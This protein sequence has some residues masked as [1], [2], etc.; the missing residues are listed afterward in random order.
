MTAAHSPLAFLYSG[1]GAQWPG[2]GQRLLTESPAFAGWMQELDAYIRPWAHFSVL[3]E[4]CAP[5]ES[6]RL[7]EASVAQPLL[8][9]MQVALTRLLRAEGL[10]AAAVAGHSVGEIAAAWAAGRLTLDEGIR[11]V[12]ARSKVQLRARGRGTMAAV[13]LPEAAM[14][15]ILV[16]ADN[17]VVIAGVNSPRS[18]TL[19]GTEAALHALQPQVRARR[20]FF[21]L[22]DLE[23]AFHSPQMDVLHAA[24]LQRLS[25]LNPTVQGN[26]AFVSTVTGARLDD[27]PLDADYW[28]R[29]VREP[30]RF[31]DALAA[32]L[33]MGCRT[34]VEIG[35]HAILQRYV[36]ECCSVKEIAAT[37]V[38]IQK[39]A[40]DGLR[41]LRTAIE[42]VRTG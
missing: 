11:V 18:V 32:L 5:P 25:G 39:K 2:M 27:A 30:V 26:C 34:F 35:P 1:N 4:M 7:G 31:A 13:G 42:A 23:Y 37:T 14:R 41:A 24:L 20:A 19:A 3:E 40:E 12:C 6:S 9:A 29:N 8:F 10:H 33:A 38:A 36:A 22:L 21:R 15:E 16:Q 28:W 17:G